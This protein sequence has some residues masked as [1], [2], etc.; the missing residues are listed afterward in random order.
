MKVQADVEGFVQSIYVFNGRVAGPHTLNALC[1]EG[2]ARGRT[3]WGK[4][5]FDHFPHDLALLVVEGDG[6]RLSV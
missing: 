4:H 2:Q 3:E 6:A 1:D 5:T